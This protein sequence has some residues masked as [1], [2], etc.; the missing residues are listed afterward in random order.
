MGALRRSPVPSSLESDQNFRRF[1]VPMAGDGPS[2]WATGANLTFASENDL[3]EFVAAAFPNCTFDD[4]AI[5]LLSTHILNAFGRVA[6]SMVVKG[7]VHLTDR[8][9]SVNV[10]NFNPSHHFCRI[11]WR[12]IAVVSDEPGFCTT[13]PN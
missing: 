4:L 2:H 5:P 9:I 8:V 3:S 7:T 13:E 1:N 11:A 10:L 6:D 12:L